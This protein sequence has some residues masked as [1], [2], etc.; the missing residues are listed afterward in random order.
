[1]EV[2]THAVI[3]EASRSEST[4]ASSDGGPGLN[5]GAHRAGRSIFGTEDDSVFETYIKE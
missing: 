1:M 5:R 3:V 2:M 4:C